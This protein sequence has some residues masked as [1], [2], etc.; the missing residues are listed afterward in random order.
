[1][2]YIKGKYQIIKTKL[3]L[4]FYYFSLEEYMKVNGRIIKEMDTVLSNLKT[5]ILIKATIKII[6]HMAKV[7]SHG[8]V[9][10]LITGSGN[11]EKRLGMEYG[12]IKLEIL[13]LENG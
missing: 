1:M 4:E 7:F 3:A 12:K 6:F 2:L 9:A 11:M 8:R 13:I 5:V 10:K